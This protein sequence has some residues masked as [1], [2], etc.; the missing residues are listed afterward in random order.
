MIIL[1]KN[2][3]WSSNT[4]GIDLV[5]CGSVDIF[6]PIFI[7]F[8]FISLLLLTLRKSGGSFS[9]LIDVSTMRDD[10]CKAGGA[11]SPGVEGAAELLDGLVSRSAARALPKE[12]VGAEKVLPRLAGGEEGGPTAV[13][14]IVRGGRDTASRVGAAG[15]NGG[16]TK[17]SAKQGANKGVG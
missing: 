2:H 3:E 14:S 4:L 9:L 16:C 8:D 10:I 17:T 13:V 1:G 5:A 7:S 6:V 15:C 11:Q 12:V